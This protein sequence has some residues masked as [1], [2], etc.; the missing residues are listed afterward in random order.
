MAQ[1][2]STLL[3]P[4]LLPK[5]CSTMKAGRRSRA[6]GG[7]RTTPASVSPF[8]LNVMRSSAIAYS[9]LS[10]TVIDS[11]IAPSCCLSMCQMV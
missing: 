8:D 1:G 6:F 11:G 3:E 5:P 9:P 7:T 4:L 10:V 2:S